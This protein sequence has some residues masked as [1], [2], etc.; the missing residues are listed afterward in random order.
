MQVS[1]L[2]YFIPTF[3]CINLSCKV[4]TLLSLDLG[5]WMKFS[6]TQV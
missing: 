6:L 5:F 4:K 3:S 1:D 2:F